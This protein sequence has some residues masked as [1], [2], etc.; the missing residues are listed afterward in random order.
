MREADAATRDAIDLVTHVA[1]DLRSPLTSILFLTDALRS[2]ESGPLSAA[3]TE[4]LTLIYSAAFRLSALVD[5]LT[6]YAQ[7]G[8]DFLESVPV[9]FLVSDVFNSVRD[10]VR[11]IAL[12]KNL[13]LRFSSDVS[14]RRLGHPA[15]LGRI[16]LNLVTNALKYTEQGCVESRAVHRSAS[17]VEFSVRDTGP[18]LSLDVLA[19]A[20]EQAQ[21]RSGAR[22]QRFSTSG[23][24][25]VICRRLIRAMRGELRIESNGTSG[26]CVSFEIDLP[27][28]KGVN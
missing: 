16:M 2:G 20:R 19:A 8:E 27:I 24:G 4:Q 11:P 14:D 17:C 28:A 21:S 6:Q 13:D 18:G 1:H 22:A 26:T 12:E 15:A 10:I 7:R 9:P 25:L 5:D 23:L 3:Q